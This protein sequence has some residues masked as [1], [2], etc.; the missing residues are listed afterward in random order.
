[1]TGTASSNPTSWHAPRIRVRR[2]L[3]GLSRAMFPR[4]LSAGVTLL[5]LAVP[6]NIGYA[7]IAGLPPTAGLYTLI[8]PSVVFALFTTSRQLVAAPDAASAA[9]V[10]ASLTGMAAV[11]SE[12][13]VD[14]AAA[15]AIVGAAVFGLCWLFRLG[16]LANFLSEA[17]LVGFVGGLAVEILLSQTAKMLGL[18]LE[19]EGFLTELWSLVVQLPDASGASV[20]LAALSGL[21][22][23][24][25]RRLS[26]GLP[27]ALVVLV[28]TTVVT[29]SAG[30]QDRGVAVLGS[31]PSGLP[32][33][34]FPQLEASEWAAVAPA[35]FA[36]TLVALAEGLLTA[37]R[38]A[39]RNHYQ[40]DANAELFAFGGANAASGL[41]GGFTIGSSASRTAAVDQT[42]SRT[43]VPALI[44][45]V[46][47][48]FL[49]LWGTGLLTNIPLPALGA[50]IALAVI[51]ILGIPEL[52]R[53]WRMRRSEFWVGAVSL[54]G[55]LAVGPIRGVIVAFF[56]SVVDIARRAANPPS[57]VIS[58]SSSRDRFVSHVPGATTSPDAVVVFRFA[59]PLFFA[60]AAT[61]HDHI[62]QIVVGDTVPGSTDAAVAAPVQCVVLDCEGITDVDVT[63]AGA[64]EAALLTCREAGAALVVSR[65]RRDLADTL[66]HYGLLVQLP[67]YDS[68]EAAVAAWSDDGPDARR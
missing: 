28:V 40:V 2:G 52:R 17:V 8:V 5:A 23:L 54:V 47:T 32:P 11:G 35:A 25:G 12:H 56:I 57:T 30:L 68:N 34:R 33:L 51:P 64:L 4:E 42:G 39:E 24:G 3:I 16:F 15:Q 36:M 9:M 31:V 63:G 21:I 45:A 14:L 26:R 13:Y 49:L 1:M 22:I 43:Q 44:A 59:A 38:Y 20:L 65:L 66:D 46:A 27:W 18:S 60:N 53:L 58:R 61:F 62:R 67:V 50:I 41:T 6:L 48:V 37:R 7:Q 55:V 19:G 29:V 10:A